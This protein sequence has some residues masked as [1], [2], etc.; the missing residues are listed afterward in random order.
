[1]RVLQINSV[2]GIRSTGKIVTEIAEKLVSEGHECLIAYG[3]EEVPEEFQSIS[4]RI[5]SYNSVRFN[6]LAARIRDNEGFN[7]CLE[8]KKFLKWADE[9]NPDLLWLH[10]LH[11]YYINIKLLF[12]WIKSRPAMKVKWTLHD[13]W[14]FTGHCAYFILA[15]CYKWQTSC[16]N[17]PQYKKYPNSLFFD[18]SK[19]NYLK[20]KKCF[21][22]VNNMTIIVPSNWLAN[23]VK[24]S[25]LKDYS[26]VVEHNKV[27]TEVFKFTESNFRKKYNLEEKKII[28][29][30]A[31]AWGRSKGLFEFVELSKLLDDSYSIV[32]VGVTEKQQ[33]LLPP[34][35]IA[36]PVTDNAKELA[37]IYSAADVFV[38]PSKQETFGMTTLEAISCNTKAIVYKN[39]ACEEVVNLYGGVS[40]E[41]TPM[42]IYREILRM[43]N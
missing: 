30:V 20:K 8:T 28:L 34:E 9:Y 43:F 5:G 41:Q 2:C 12:D 22:N 1:M 4:Y 33:N 17:C 19:S 7:A 15:D 11:G 26:I 18:N 42:D 36:V 14:A 24:N 40:V 37:E 3:R 38:N 16:Q 29:G 21:T 10:N 35:I 6:V 31:S 39:T 25:F 23:L 32:L 13:C 27:N